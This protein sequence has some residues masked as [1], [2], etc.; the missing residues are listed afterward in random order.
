[1]P[2]PRVFSY[3]AA[4]L[5]T[6]DMA[7]FCEVDLKTIHN[8]VNKGEIPHFR[9][10]GRHL[11]FRRIDVLEFLR[12]YGYSIP[13]ILGGG[14]PK[15]VV[16]DDET[17]S[18]AIQRALAKRFDVLTFTDPLDAVA[19][20]AKFAPDALVY[21]ADLGSVDAIHFLERLQKS[22]ATARIRVFVLSDRKELREKA[23]KAG[24]QKAFSKGDV[25]GVRDALE[26]LTGIA[27]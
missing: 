8:W 5:T 9:T 20:L 19:A 10:P 26:E 14:K 24:A 22:E 7:R 23:V 12:K 1:M 21:D 6:T 13:T 16:V 25:Y 15:V 17:R 27:K 4:F 2:A 3:R 11:R 18:R